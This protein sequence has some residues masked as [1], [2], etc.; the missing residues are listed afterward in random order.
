MDELETANLT[1]LPYPLQRSLMKTVVAEAQ[2][3]GQAELMQ[4]WAGQ[5]ISLL[6]HHSASALVASLVAD[7][8][9]LLN[10]MAR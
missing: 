7:A 3:Q 8:T 2:E 4:L 6:R 5:S 1:V 9:S 10:R